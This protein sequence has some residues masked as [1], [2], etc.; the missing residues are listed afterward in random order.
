MLPE[1]GCVSEQSDSN[2]TKA[3]ML[4]GLFGQ[5]R[6]A[7][8]GHR[9]CSTADRHGLSSMADAMENNASPGRRIPEANH[10][11]SDAG[12]GA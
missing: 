4:G 3:Y 10:R 1:A 2:E 5:R 7:F 8:S 9:E 6:Q 12:G 11:K